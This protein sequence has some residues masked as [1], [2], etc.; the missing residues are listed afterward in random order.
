MLLRLPSVALAEA[1]ISVESRIVIASS[2]TLK[3]VIHVLR[4]L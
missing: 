4:K 3:V 2:F 1:A